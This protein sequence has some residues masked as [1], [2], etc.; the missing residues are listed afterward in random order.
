MKEINFHEIL[1]EIISATFRENLILIHVNSNG[2]EQPLH[3][4]ILIST[5]SYLLSGMHNTYSVRF[6]LDFFCVPGTQ[7]TNKR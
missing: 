3:L 7:G 2:V 4:H 6:R 1:N 5:I